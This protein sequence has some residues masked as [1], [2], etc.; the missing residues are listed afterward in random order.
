M[1]NRI[2]KI[3]TC[4]FAVGDSIKRNSQQI[5]AQMQKAK[6]AGAGI[7][8]FPECALA[9]YIGFDFP[10]FDNFDWDLLETETSRITALARKLKL[11]VVLGSVHRLGFWQNK[12]LPISDWA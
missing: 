3:A 8:H 10:N 7:T 6:K 1:N 9:G 5:C 12:Q 11:W 4:Q 2:L